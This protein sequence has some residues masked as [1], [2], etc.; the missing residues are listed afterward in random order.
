M[1]ARDTYLNVDPDDNQMWS[2]GSVTLS[3]PADGG[4]VK[5]RADT[6]WAVNWGAEDFP[7][8]TG[9]QDGA[10]ILCAAGQ[11][12]MVS[13]FSEYFR[14]IRYLNNI[15]RKRKI[16]IILGIH[17]MINIF[18]EKY[19]EFLPGGI[20]EAFGRLFGNNVKMYLYPSTRV[21]EGTVTQF[22]NMPLPEHLQPLQEYLI[23]N[24]RVQNLRC[25]DA[26]FLSINSEEVLK[27]I[28]ANE[29][30]W[31]EFVP[32]IVAN[33]IKEQALFGYINQEKVKA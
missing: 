23:R 17:N 29:P 14:L 6:D 26:K 20:L 32:G 12:V 11:T 30:G 9:T 31:E 2:L 15:T 3:D 28:K 1:G 22:E 25:N 27:M 16:G 13:N 7:A 18:N 4:G 21:V 5:F 19:Y 8:G 10:N 24:N 33:F